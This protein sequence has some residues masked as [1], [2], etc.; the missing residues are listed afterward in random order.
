MYKASKESMA[1]AFTIYHGGEIVTMEGDDPSYVECL[2][3]SNPDDG[4]KI[5]YAGTI[6]GLNKTISSDGYW[7]DL[8]GACVFPGFID[9]H[10]HPSMAAVL[11]TTNFITPFD[12]SLPDRPKVIGVRTERDYHKGNPIYRPIPNGGTY[13]RTIFLSLYLLENVSQ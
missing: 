5:I 12:W 1:N 8:K 2:V 9:P 3:V 11:L 13:L 4:G 7:F 6:G 10:I